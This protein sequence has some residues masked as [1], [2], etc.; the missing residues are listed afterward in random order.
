MVPRLLYCTHDHIFTIDLGEQGHAAI[1]L[2]KDAMNCLREVGL[3][4]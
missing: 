2:S 4:E 1:I 3:L